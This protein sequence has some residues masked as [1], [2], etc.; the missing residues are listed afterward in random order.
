MDTAIQTVT[1]GPPA[2]FLLRWLGAWMLATALS[3]FLLALFGFGMPEV[4]Y[5]A[6]VDSQVPIAVATTPADHVPPV[7]PHAPFR[8]WRIVAAPPQ[9]LLPVRIGEALD[10]FFQFGL[11]LPLKVTTNSRVIFPL[12]R[13]LGSAL[14]RDRLRRWWS[15]RNALGGRDCP[16][17]W[18]GEAAF[19]MRPPSS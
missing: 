11:A 3:S 15:G 8:Y 13:C 10:R 12:R 16:R 9:R 5:G 17:P 1:R 2:G 18:A 7:A 6:D 4:D 19:Q 14:G